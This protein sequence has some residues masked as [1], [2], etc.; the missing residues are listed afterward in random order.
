[1]QKANFKG[2]T[3]LKKIETHRLR[4]LIYQ[5]VLTYPDSSIG[6]IH[7][8]IGLEIP[9]RKVRTHVYDLTKEGIFNKKS[10]SRWRKYYI[11]RKA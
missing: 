9:L 7:Q 3:N 4:E 11:D 1:M 2:K 10:D 5:D 6:E 8:R